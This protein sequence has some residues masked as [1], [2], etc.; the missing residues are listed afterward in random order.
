MRSGRLRSVPEATFS[1]ERAGG[2]RGDNLNQVIPL[3]GMSF[4]D[5]K[6]KHM[7]DAL[8]NPRSVAMIGATADS[9]KIGFRIVRNLLEQG[10]DGEMYP[11]NPKGGF[12]FEKAMLKSADDLPP[13]IDLAFLAIPQKSL[14]GALKACVEKGIR[15]V[16]ALTAGFKETGAEGSRLEQDLAQLIRRSSTRL[17]G[18]NCA[19]FCNTWGN[20]HGSMELYPPRGPISFVSQSGSLCSAFSSHMLARSCGLSKYISVGNKADVDVPDILDYLA[21]DPTTRCIALYLEDI[22][23]GTRLFRTA[24]RISLKKPIVVLK[25]GRSEAGARATLSHTGALAGQ[26]AVSE[27]FFRQTGMIRVGQL[28][29]LYDVAAA[30]SAVGRLRGNRLA[31]LSDAGGPGVLAADAAVLCGLEVPTPSPAAQKALCSVLADFASVRNPVDMTF[32]RDV[33][34]YS[35]CIEI[36]HQ[37]SMDAVL[38]TIPSHFSVKGELC[39][40]LIRAGEKYGC[41]MAVAWLAGDD[42]ERQRRDLWQ[43]GIPAFSSPEPA[44]YCLSRLAWY[45]SWLAGR[46]GNVS[47]Q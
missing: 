26:D 22:S 36:L 47:L 43:A 24:A 19:G 9:S 14:P 13:G 3:T 42:V 29:E 46:E 44:A 20:I 6:S 11:V 41:P 33:N 39:S 37:D 23:E 28:T 38:I 8:F 7:M 30:L 15:Y 2:G 31:V 18:P 40:V 27:G 16:V 45:G 35:R 21:D 25:S 17:V 12:L 32:T 5:D 34:L 4:E 10:Y 1:H